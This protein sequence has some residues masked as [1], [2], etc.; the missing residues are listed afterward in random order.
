[1]YH[2]TVSVIW[3]SGAAWLCSPAV[4][5][6]QGGK[7]LRAWLR[8]DPL[9]SSFIWLWAGFRFPRAIDSLP[10]RPVHR[11]AHNMAAY[12]THLRNTGMPS[13]KSGCPFGTRICMVSS[14]PGTPAFSWVR[15]TLS[16]PSFLW[17]TPKLLKKQ[18]LTAKGPPRSPSASSWEVPEA[19][20]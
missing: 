18:S 10:R 1:M 14:I 15:V 4:G 7:H 3:N 6:S 20:R 8:K 17:K 2:L 9:P 16:F 12:F 19:S 5:L 11:D 13:L